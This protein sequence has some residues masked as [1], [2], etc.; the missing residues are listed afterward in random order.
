[1]TPSG[2]RASCTAPRPK[3]MAGISADAVPF[4]LRNDGRDDMWNPDGRTPGDAAETM[5]ATTAAP[6]R[7]MPNNTTVASHSS[8]VTPATGRRGGVC[9]I[10]AWDEPP[11]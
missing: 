9:L 10:D 2:L 7:R 8:P 6:G 5:P 4:Q 1:M 11:P 3:R